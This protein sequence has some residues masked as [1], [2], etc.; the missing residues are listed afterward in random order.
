MIGAIFG[1]IDAFFL[2]LGFWGYVLLAMVT[3]FISPAVEN[4]RSAW[5]VFLF[6]WMVV[7]LYFVAH[8]NIVT[9]AIDHWLISIVLFVAYFLAGV[10]WAMFKY[11]KSLGK[12]FEIL[13]E[14][15]ADFCKTWIAALSKE[16]LASTRTGIGYRTDDSDEHR[17]SRFNMTPEQYAQ[18]KPL[19]L[20]E[21]KQGKIPKQLLSH[22]RNNNQYADAP[23]PTQFK[24]KITMWIVFWPWSLAYYFC[25][26]FF[27][28][29]FE[30]L[31]K[32]V[33]GVF[34]AIFERHNSKVDQ[35]VFAKSE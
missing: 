4:D 10:P 30:L 14:K 17:A 1:T 8:I 35:S 22:W 19:M 7:L 34:S 11:E 16:N 32:M 24:K 2:A 3:I 31:W 23:T 29:L 28:D 20:E 33:K 5:G 21:L 18:A 12:F 27:H 9:F 26:D 25:Y 6:A 15:K 13:A